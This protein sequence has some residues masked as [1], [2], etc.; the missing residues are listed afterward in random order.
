MASDKRKQKGTIGILLENV[1]LPFILDGT[2]PEIILTPGGSPC[3]KL[4]S[5]THMIADNKYN[6]D[7]IFFG[8]KLD[9]WVQNTHKNISD[10]IK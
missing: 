3:T 8:K 2:K 10:S 9:E 6:Y 4:K 5:E 7:G 1:D